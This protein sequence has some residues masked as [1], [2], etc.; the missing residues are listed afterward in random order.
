MY[1]RIAA[2]CAAVLA[3][4]VLPSFVS[5]HPHELGEVYVAWTDQVTEERGR[6]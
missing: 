4:A 6:A 2:V 3:C 1:K 5:A